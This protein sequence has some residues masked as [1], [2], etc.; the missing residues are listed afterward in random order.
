MQWDIGSYQVDTDRQ[1]L[2][3][4]RIYE[5]L[6][7]TYWANNRCFDEV[8]T[9]WAHSKV[10]FGVYSQSDDGAQIGC[11]RVV[12]DT[13]TFGWLAD[14]FIAPENRGQGLG[15]FLVERITE[16]PDCARLRLFLLGTRDAHGLYAQYGWEPPYYVERYMVRTPQKP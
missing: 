2:D 12:T 10:V 13:R 14:V 16:H 15:K 6:R 1:R 9:A 3:M 8:S 7:T 4:P 5:F 11:A